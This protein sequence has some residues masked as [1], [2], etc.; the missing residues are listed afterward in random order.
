MRAGTPSTGGRNVRG[1]RSPAHAPDASRDGPSLTT[2]E[3]R[4]CRDL[5]SERDGAEFLTTLEYRQC[6]DLSSER[7]GQDVV[8]RYQR[9]RIGWSGTSAELRNR[10][11]RA[12]SVD[13]RRIRAGPRV[14]P[15]LPPPPVHPARSRRCDAV[16]GSTRPTSSQPSPVGAA[17]PDSTCSFP[18]QSPAAGPGRSPNLLA[19]VG[20]HHGRAVAEAVERR[21]QLRDPKPSDANNTTLAVASG[22]TSSGPRSGSTTDGT[23]AASLPTAVTAAARAL[24]G[25]GPTW[26]P[27]RTRR[28]PPPPPWRV[29]ATLTGRPASRRPAPVHPAASQINMASADVG[30]HRPHRH[31]TPGEGQTD[32]QPHQHRGRASVQPPRRPGSRR[33]APSASSAS[34]ASGLRRPV[35]RRDPGRARP[36]SGDRQG[37]H[38]RDLRHRERDR[39]DARRGPV[40]LAPTG[41]PAGSDPTTA[42]TGRTGDAERSTPRKADGRLRRA[43]GVQQLGQVP[44]CGHHLLDDRRGH[45][46]HEHRHAGPD[47][48][49]G[50]RRRPLSERTTSRATTA[51]TSTTPTATATDV[52]RVHTDARNHSSATTPGRID[53]V[54][55]RDLPTRP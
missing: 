39:H 7:W 6:R 28:G 33:S 31:R 23:R 10:S 2:L 12:G 29:T 17:S 13:A 45:H 54:P 9:E 40:D 15:T 36:S 53:T 20:R 18:G 30:S 37:H 8:G 44:R 11:A 25:T 49:A 43:G 32:Q 27:R 38:R 46:D 1:N 41:R 14:R 48:S 47:R 50:A 35:R 51:T 22:E 34:S 21:D 16:S 3:Y 55:G 5:S 19:G 42:P 4:Q 26:R 52:S 24:V